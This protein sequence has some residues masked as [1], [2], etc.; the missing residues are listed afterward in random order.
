MEKRSSL[1]TTA[2][3][4]FTAGL[5]AG[6]ANFA[7][8]SLADD[9]DA[10]AS[11]PS[12][13]PTLTSPIPNF[14]EVIPGLYRGGIPYEKGLEYLNSLNIK[15]D[16]DL[17]GGDVYEL[18]PAMAG[19]ISWGEKPQEVDEERAEADLLNLTFINEP[20]SAYDKVTPNEDQEIDRTLVIMN[21]PNSRPLFIHCEHGIDRTGLLV[22]LYEVKYLG[23]SIDAAHL[24]WEAFGHRGIEGLLTHELDNYFYKKAQEI[25][26]AKN[27]QPTQTS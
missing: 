9:G 19:L 2:L 3:S 24:E 20:L 6:L 26:S 17:Q 13:A 22:A 23:Y 5:I 8:P 27:Q 25:I 7:L 1:I 12:P 10:P 15:T 14:A 21:D 4:L 16:V 18:L 11:A